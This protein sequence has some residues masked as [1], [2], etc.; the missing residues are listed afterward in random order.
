MFD[1][2]S[3]GQDF[4]PSAKRENAVNDL[5][6]Q[7]NTP[8]GVPDRNTYSS[9]LVTVPVKLIHADQ[10]N[11]GDLIGFL[12]SGEDYAESVPPSDWE[13]TG[14]RL[15]IVRSLLRK[16]EIADVA[17]LGAV[18]ASVTIA[19]TGHG[20]AGPDGSGQLV[21]CEGSTQF[22]I[23]TAADKLETGRQQCMV[24]ISSP[25]GHAEEYFGPF[26]VTLTE[27][28]KRISVSPGFLNRNGQVVSVPEKTID[29][30][31]G[32][33]CVHSEIKGA[34]WTAPEFRIVSAPS[35]SDYPVA[36]L[37]ESGGAKHI[38]QYHVPMA[39]IILSKACPVAEA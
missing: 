5:L 30:K 2:I 13:T 14:A 33:L 25:G 15:G 16:N 28:G 39:F 3:E 24:F 18:S 22:Q 9:R 23:L 32:Y 1:R 17:A 6:N 12:Y 31:T 7:F 21:S 29:W 8:G 10:L 34:N 36:C 19:D 26:K 27:D 37:S 35:A 11:A 20:Y 38:D 4:V